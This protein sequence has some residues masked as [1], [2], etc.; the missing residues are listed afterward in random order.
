MAFEG[1][2]EVLTQ[3]HQ[4]ALIGIRDAMVDEITKVVRQYQKQGIH[5]DHEAFLSGIVKT[6]GDMPDIDR[7]RVLF[8]DLEDTNPYVEGK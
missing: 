8:Q 3:E 6:Y 5:F 1:M 2:G 7:F 4:D